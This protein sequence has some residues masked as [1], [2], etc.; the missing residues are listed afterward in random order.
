M[1]RPS[2][3]ARPSPHAARQPRAR[4]VDRA[5]PAT[6]K[7]QKLAKSAHA[8]LPCDTCH[9]SHE[10]YPHPA[11]IP[12]P[13]CATCHAG[14]GGRLRQRRAR[15]GAQARQRRRARLRRLP[16]QRARTAVAQVASLPRRPCRILAACATARW[17]SNTAPACTG[18]RWR[19][20]ITQAPLCTDCHGEHKI[21][22]H[23][24]AASPVNAAHIRDTCGSCHGDVRLTRQFGLPSDRL[25]SFDSL[26]PRAGRQRGRRRPWPTAP[27]AT[28]C[29]TSCRRPT[30]IPPSIPR[31]C[32]RP[33]ANATPAPGTRFAI[34]QVH[35]A[36]GGAEPA[37]AALGARVLPAADPGDHRAD[38]AAQRRRLGA[39]AHS[40]AFPRCAASPAATAAS[41]AAANSACCRSSACSTPCWRFRS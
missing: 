19:S 37:A 35:V 9:E 29:T 30:R 12:K 18:K 21:I 1:D 20:G 36:E 31:T 38:A 4:P 39:Q 3:L 7:A 15:P 34:G 33:A 13:V 10:K 2:C 14:P 40:R 16:R 25:V 28:A 32:P 26:L 17:P 5:P 24:N 22:K 41:P 11:G 23:T 27:V 6:T 8:G